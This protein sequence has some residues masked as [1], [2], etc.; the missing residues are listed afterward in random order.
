MRTPTFALLVLLC[1]TARA[2]FIKQTDKGASLRERVA[3]LRGSVHERTGRASSLQATA[4][5]HAL[6]GVGVGVGVAREV[7][8]GSARTSLFL[9][10]KFRLG[11]GLLA[12]YGSEIGHYASPYGTTVDVIPKTSEST[13][14]AGSVGMGASYSKSE[15]Y[16]LTSTQHRTYGVTRGYGFF[17]GQEKRGNLKIPLFTMRSKGARLLDRAERRLDEADQAALVSD[18][19]KADGLRQKAGRLL[20]KVERWVND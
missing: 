18:Y 8:G 10:G 14:V 12:T 20:W 1:G 9:S 15:T 5:G 7:A 6:I 16:D 11:P 2:D 3:R 4:D 19:A 13:S 17:W